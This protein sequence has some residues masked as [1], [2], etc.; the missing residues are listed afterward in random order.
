MFFIG[1]LELFQ[2]VINTQFQMSP[3]LLSF[4]PSISIWCYYLTI[5]KSDTL[6]K[7]HIRTN[8]KNNLTGILL[9]VRR[10]YRKA[11]EKL[12]DFL[13]VFDGFIFFLFSLCFLT[14]IYISSMVV[15]LI[16]F[17]IVLSYTQT[18]VQFYFKHFFE[19]RHS[20]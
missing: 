8:V 14:S 16:C 10:T 5:N 17:S 13:G 9:R 20:I 11:D 19:N 6:N 1:K 3:I 15:A 12:L 4:D 7:K 2:H 18:L